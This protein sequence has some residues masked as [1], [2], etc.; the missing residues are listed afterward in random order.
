LDNTASPMG[1]RLLRRWIVFPLKDILKINERLDLVEY[2]IK[3]PE[4][5]NSISQKIKQ[6]GDVERLVSKIPLRKINPRELLQ[7]GR[8]LKFA[9]EIK[10]L[11]SASS[12]DYLKRLADAINP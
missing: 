6:C 4:L 10:Q 9:H 8:G 5:R 12:N 1:A 11:C 7:L 2:L 3:D